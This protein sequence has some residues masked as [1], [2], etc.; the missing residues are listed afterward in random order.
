MLQSVSNALYEIDGALR[1]EYEALA[2]Q[3][4]SLLKSRL[5]FL[6]QDTPCDFQHQTLQSTEQSIAIAS[7]G[8]PLSFEN[9]KQFN[10]IERDAMQYA[11]DYHRR[12]PNPKVKRG[13]P[14][15]IS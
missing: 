12:T 9:L 15:R 14:R 6:L 7:E 5:P 4:Y 8:A 11:T 3:Y 1:K 10:L 2:V 13:M